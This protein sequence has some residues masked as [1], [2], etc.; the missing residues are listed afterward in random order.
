MPPTTPPTIA[1]VLDFLCSTALSEPLP[2]VWEG[3]APEEVEVLETRSVL[4]AHLYNQFDLPVIR[5][6]W[7]YEG[8]SGV[9]NIEDAHLGD[10]ALARGL[11]TF[12]R[13]TVDIRS[14]YGC[15]VN[16]SIPLRILVSS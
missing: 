9:Q 6:C 2:P 1:P 3:V 8:Y 5:E 11:R 10:R 13:R 14:A 12:P 7:G 16:K 4:P 15:K